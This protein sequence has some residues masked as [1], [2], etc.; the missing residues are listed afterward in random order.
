MG[1]YIK[2]FSI[3][4]VIIRKTTKL[5]QKAEV[6]VESTSKCKIISRV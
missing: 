3:K 2:I 5:L 1:I 4:I 6:N